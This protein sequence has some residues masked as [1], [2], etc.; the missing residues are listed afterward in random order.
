LLIYYRYSH[1]QGSGGYIEFLARSALE[2]ATGVRWDLAT[3]LPLEVVPG[4]NSD[5]DE[6]IL[7]LPSGQ[8]LRFGRAYGF[9]NIQSVLRRLKR[10]QGELCFVEVMACPSGCLNGGGQLRT[11]A[12][13]SAKTRESSVAT[14]ARIMAVDRAL[15]GCTTDPSGSGGEIS[16]ALLQRPEDSPLVKYVARQLELRSVK[17]GD[18]LSLLLH[19]R[20]HAVPKLEVIAP[21]ATPW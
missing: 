17:G 12:D 7:R 8:T 21:M 1:K 4:R 15:H 11:I 5:I 2:T 19:T 14:T 18:V 9:R 3:P 10:Q 20:Y 6:S 16:N 13:G